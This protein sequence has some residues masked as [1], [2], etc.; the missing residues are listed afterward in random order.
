MRVML[1]NC[2]YLVSFKSGCV[3]FSK[4]DVRKS[5]CMCECAMGEKVLIIECGAHVLS[6]HGADCAGVKTQEDALAA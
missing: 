3:L 1:Q 4:F 2:F 6:T 5:A